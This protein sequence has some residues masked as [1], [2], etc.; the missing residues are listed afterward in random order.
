MKKLLILDGNSIANRAFFGVRTL[1]T[2]DGLP[3]NAVY[4]FLTIVKKH[5]DGLNPDYLACAFDVH[6][7]TFRHI[8]YPEYKANRHGMP[9]ELRVQMPYIKRAATDIGFRVIEAPGFEA[10]DILGT[11][12]RMGDETGE[13]ETYVLTGDRDS[14]Q[15]ISEHTRVILAKTKEDVVYDPG[16]FFEE[17][18]VTPAQFID[19]KALMGDSSDNVPG[20]PGVGEKTALKLIQLAGDLDALYADETFYGQKG[21]L[22]EKLANG[23]ESAFL[24]RE[25]VTINREAPIG[26]PEELFRTSESDPDDFIA[27]CGE[28]EFRGMGERFGLAGPAEK[29][30]EILVTEAE[31][32]SGLSFDSPVAVC[33]ENGEAALCAEAEQVTLVRDV[34]GEDIAGFCSGNRIV[35]HDLKTLLR[36]HGMEDGADCAFDTMLAAYLLDPGR[37]KYTLQDVA[38]RYGAGEVKDLVSAAAALYELYQILGKQLEETGMDGLLRDIEIPLS[39][40]LARM[41]TAG[42]RIDPKGICAYAD[43]LLK[44]ESALQSAI[45]MEAGH[46]FNINSPKQLAGVL[47][48][49]IGLPAGKKTKSGYSTD[50]ETLEELLPYHPII[51]DILEYRQVTKLRGTYGYPLAEAAD[52]SGRIHTKFNQTGTATGRL[53]S[54][55]PNL[56]NIPVRGDLGRELRKYFIADD[57]CVLI[58]ADYSQIELRLLSALADDRVMQKAFLDGIDIHTSVA[59]EVFGVPAS[60]VTP[61]LRRRAKAVNFGIVY[62]IGEYS[63]SRDLGITVKQAKAY[64]NNYLSTYA[65]VDAYLRGTVEKARED[66]WTVTYFGRRRP[67]P[68]LKSSNRNLRAFGERVAMNSPIQGTAADVIKIAMVRVDRAL[69]ESGLPARLIMQ[70]HDELIVE[71][72]RDCAEEVA[73]ILTREMR[74][75]ASFDVPLET[76]CGTGENWLEAK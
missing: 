74:N 19:V 66:G 73:G 38:S 22:A 12:A 69:R 68:E 58:D 25:L 14:L 60:K 29:E 26:G 48:D 27:L 64:I 53:A 75:A 54:S 39:G 56:Q 30:R 43:E 33:F 37:S 7:P 49:E 17:Y 2:H 36:A 18:G 6:Q 44:R 42:F 67:I 65:G 15:L 9:E 10:D 3:T 5:L 35:C 70:V 45:W 20:V 16:R 50:A 62:G 34:T 57:G 41:E 8:R 52:P 24:S 4:G 63:L 59:S 47:F 76:E 21:A 51:G 11:A 28:L 72:G 1:T 23:R 40:V 32:L 55:D 71:A 31:S 61:E 46:P 13:I